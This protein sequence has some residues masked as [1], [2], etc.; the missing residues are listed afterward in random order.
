MQTSAAG[1]PELPRRRCRPSASGFTLLELLVVL[2]IVA[3]VSA[4]VGFA[5]RDG[6]QTQLERE[7]LRLNALFEAARA[8]SQIS[9]VPV[10][11]RVTADGFQFEGLPSSGRTEDDLP[12]AWLDADTT[13]RVEAAATR[14]A[15]EPDTVVLGPEPILLPQGVTL[16]S[17]SQP[18][19]RV[20]L[21]TDGVRPFAVQVEIP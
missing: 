16:H 18:G 10:R 6:T 13:A 4:G 9:G 19:Q 8:R 12:Q 2:A 3:M 5:L 7:A 14:P 11:W 1:S 21:A 17:R 15:I 20:L